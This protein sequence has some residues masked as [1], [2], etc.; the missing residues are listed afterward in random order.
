[1]YLT[2]N[3][4]KVKLGQEEAFET[5]WKSRDSHLK[6]VPGFV[7]FHLMK[8]AEKE[9]YRLYA[10]HT[11]WESEEAFLNWTKSEAFR[12]AHSGARSS[13]DIYLGPPELEIFDSI[14][15]VR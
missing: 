15:S 12:K 3:R 4:F 8:G 1:M 2:M 7:E 13:A 5:V 9:G 10:S 14:Q 11:M 6:E